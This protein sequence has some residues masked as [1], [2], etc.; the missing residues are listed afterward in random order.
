MTTA[1]E[2]IQKEKLLQNCLEIGSAIFEG[3]NRLKSKYELIGDGRGRGLI[4]YF[5]KL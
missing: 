4:F 2:V 1:M 3:L 5:F